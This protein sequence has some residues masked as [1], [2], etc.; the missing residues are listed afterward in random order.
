VEKVREQLIRAREV[1]LKTNT[2]WA[3]NLA[4]RDQ[5]GEDPAGLLAPYDELVKKLSAA[6]IQQAARQYFDTANYA[7]FV[8][9][10]EK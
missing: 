9:L 10:P 4:G 8:L 5:N 7:R 1:D 2:Y 6:Q 3:V